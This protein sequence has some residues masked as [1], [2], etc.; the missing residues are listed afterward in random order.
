MPPRSMRYAPCAMRSDFA[1]KLS[2]LMNRIG[3]I[4][5]FAEIKSRD[6]RATYRGFD[7][8]SG[9]VVLVKIFKP[10]HLPDEKTLARFR[11]EAAIYA[12]LNHPH[13][14][15]LVKFG[16]EENRP[17]LALE[18][19]EG[20]NLRA[21]LAQRSPLPDDIAAY[22]TLAML[23]GLEEIHRHNII[24][25]DLKPENIML[26]HDGSV[27]I[28]DFDLAITRHKEQAALPSH[29]RTI[30]GKAGQVTTDHLLSGSPGYFAPEA[31]LGEP[32]STRADLF[33][34]GV[35]LYEMFAG[36]RPFAA[37]TASGEM[38]AVV[39]LPHLS[40]AKFN[41][42]IPEEVEKLINQLLAKSP[43]ERPAGAAEISKRLTTRFIIPA[44][45]TQS[46]KL[47]SFLRDPQSYQGE[48]LSA[49]ISPVIK[50]TARRTLPGW[51]IAAALMLLA[52]I[53]IYQ[54]FLKN[55]NAPATL[56]LQQTPKAPEVISRDDS[57]SHVLNRINVLDNSPERSAGF[58]I[59]DAK[60]TPP[61]PTPTVAGEPPPAQPFMKRIIVRNV[62]WAYLFVN[63][64][65]I[66]QTPRSEPVTLAAGV[67]SFV[68]KKPQFPPIVFK[69]VVDS[70]TADTLTFSL[71]ERVAQVE[72]KIYPWAEIYVD[73]V[74]RELSAENPTIYLL[75]G[76]HHF[77]FVHLQ[78]EKNETLSLQAGEARRL[79]VNMFHG[80][81]RE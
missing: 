44:P 76:K 30:Q 46:E 40:P 26:G 5:L 45:A 69:V 25:R 68:F 12:S 3:P 48:N 79:E 24:H 16:V 74:Q 80:T 17:F 67:Y 73:G 19:I 32:V 64:D 77:R 28:C 31:I 75:P 20:Q 14:V 29:F 81:K 50:P 6:D 38:N 55:N 70:T 60:K 41:N 61:L 27:K 37:P 8:A 34:A 9:R 36:T 18:F 7:T 51:R 4:Q 2:L 53:F 33:A 72:V 52:M 21:L 23:A 42:A 62:P 39:R 54:S 59:E 57:N 1:N 71:L 10:A 15:R 35:I 66:G 11:E 47:Q 65:S 43:S 49:A 22:I 58:K 63:G 13:V 78:G 56:P